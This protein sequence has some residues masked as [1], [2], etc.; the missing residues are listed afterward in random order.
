MHGGRT[1]TVFCQRITAIHG[2][3]HFGLCQCPANR[4]IVIP[5]VLKFISVFD[6][7][8]CQTKPGIGRA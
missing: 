6:R 4:F 3:K 1:I 8:R 2:R 7:A 5:V